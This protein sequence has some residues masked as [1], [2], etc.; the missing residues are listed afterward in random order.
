MLYNET[1]NDDTFVMAGTE[2][3]GEYVV[4]LK[5][6][7]GAVGY[8]PDRARGVYRVR[9]E[10]DSAE[11]ADRLAPTFPGWKQPGNAG[12]PRFSTEVDIED[13]AGLLAA[14]TLA[15]AALKV[16][17]QWVR[18]NVDAPDWAYALA[19]PECEVDER[20]ELTDLLRRIGVKG[21]SPRW[22]LATLALKVN[23][24][25]ERMVAEVQRRKLPDAEAAATWTTDALYA[26]L[27]VQKRE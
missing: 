11:A 18:G 22:K 20:K 3:T 13:R 8:R 5:T 9:V 2:G 15:G 12:Q 16:D 10:P 26:A 21:V 1:V 6:N 17:A 23:Q 14:L 4:P 27:V 25:R 24:A 7:H 19:K